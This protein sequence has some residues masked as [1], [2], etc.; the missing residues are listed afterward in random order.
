PVYEIIDEATAP[1]SD[2]FEPDET[3]PA[4]PVTPDATALEDYLIEQP[5]ELAPS[6]LLSD[7]L[8]PDLAELER[9]VGSFEA[10]EIPVQEA[11]APPTAPHSV[12]DLLTPADAPTV[13][14][15]IEME[16]GGTVA[17][18]VE[19]AQE[20]TDLLEALGEP[21]GPAHAPVAEEIAE[22]PG[23]T[24]D[25]AAD[26]MALG[27]GELPEIA[28]P[29]EALVVHPAIDDD[30]D[31]LEPVAESA[32]VADLNDLLTSLSDDAVL[33][34]SPLVI[35]TS[36]VL[37]DEPDLL[38]VASEAPASGVISTDAFLADFSPS[39]S[40]FSLGDELT[41]LTG[42]GTASKRPQATAKKLPDMGEHVLR[43][44]QHVDR[45]LVEKIIE[46]VKKL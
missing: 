5:V 11:V 44:D 7:E 14:V 4:E 40:Q 12:E 38:D 37:G 26:L 16:F 29:D 28:A 34:E 36:A 22:V 45:Q 8:L 46:G 32:T 17:P 43:R 24:G 33:D 31:G 42:G 1:A 39:E 19:G 23:R 25:F 15:P 3:V 10:P 2:L 30:V 35:D 6:G 18:P 41:A 27:L 9:A 13:E 21:A 20:L